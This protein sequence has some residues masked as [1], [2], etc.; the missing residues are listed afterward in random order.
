[1]SWIPYTG[2]GINTLEQRARRSIG[3]ILLLGTHGWTHHINRNAPIGTVQVQLV[4]E[5]TAANRV[6]I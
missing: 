4:V 2:F 3:Q 1:M 6:S 5:S